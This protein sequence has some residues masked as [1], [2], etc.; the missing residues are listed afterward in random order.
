[1]NDTQK[2]LTFKRLRETKNTIRFE[3]EV[4]TGHPPVIGTIYIQKWFVGD[5]AEITVTVEKEGN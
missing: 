3:E 5:A 4:A 1:M 2:V